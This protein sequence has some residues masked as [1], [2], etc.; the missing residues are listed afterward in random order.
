MP[1]LRRPR[2][3]PGRE[4]FLSDVWV[5]CEHCKGARFVEATLQVRWNGMTIGDVLQMSVTKALAFF[6]H[7]WAIVR[8]LQP[9]EIAGLGYLKLG[10]P[11]STP[12]A[13][14]RP[15]A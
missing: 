8:K 15:N 11:A 2:R 13:A 7:H 1:T 5:K 14:V 9:L 6:S 3:D 12:V 4:H 10:Q